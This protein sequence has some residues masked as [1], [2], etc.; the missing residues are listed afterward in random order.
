MH[1]LSRLGWAINSLRS[2]TVIVRFIDKDGSKKIVVV[3]RTLFGCKAIGK[4]KISQ[5]FDPTTYHP[6]WEPIEFTTQNDFR[7]I[8]AGR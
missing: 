4:F 6:E 1:S 7:K 5:E 2:P 8:A 3:T